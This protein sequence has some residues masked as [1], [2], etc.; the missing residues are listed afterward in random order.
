MFLQESLQSPS[1]P[2]HSKPLQVCLA[3]T[4]GLL[5]FNYCKRTALQ[6]P[7]LRRS[8]LRLKKPGEE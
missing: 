8:K 1:R 5:F 7:I 4:Q 6:L 2:T 3:S